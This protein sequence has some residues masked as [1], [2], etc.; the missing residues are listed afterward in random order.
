MYTWVLMRIKW[1]NLYKTHQVGL[2][3][4]T[5]KARRHE[6]IKV[7]KPSSIFDWWISILDSNIG[8]RMKWVR[9]CYL[10]CCGLDDWEIFQYGRRWNWLVFLRK[11]Q[12]EDKRIFLWISEFCSMYKGS[13]DSGDWDSCRARVHVRH[14]GLDLHGI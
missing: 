14:H 3:S 7:F 9:I 6:I 10:S 5:E 4:L 1:R 11:S 2:W 13:E 12:C 8:K